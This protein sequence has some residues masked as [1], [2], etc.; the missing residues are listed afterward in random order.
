MSDSLAFLIYAFVVYLIHLYATSGRNADS[1][2]YKS[3]ITLPATA[4]VD[5]PVEYELAARES[6]DGPHKWPSP[7]G[8]IPN[9]ERGNGEV[10]HVVGDDDE[11]DDGE[12]QTL[13]GA[14]R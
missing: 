1:F 5:V 6:T 4:G 3:A 7:Y 8:R 10:L 11:E 13:V 14:R 12:A 9:V 2:L